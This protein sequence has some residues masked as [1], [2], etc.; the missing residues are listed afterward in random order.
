VSKLKK[1]DCEGLP[2]VD[3]CRADTSRRSPLGGIDRTHHLGRVRRR[4][5]AHP[6]AVDKQY[7]RE[8]PVPE[9]DGKHGEQSEGSG[10]KNQAADRERT[11]AK[12][13]REDAGD[14]TA[15]EEP[16]GQRKHVDR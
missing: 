14:G 4:E 13:V 6:K 5:T 15:D 1:A 9:V 8:R 11:R 10:G 7:Q 12:A 16:D 2:A 3:R